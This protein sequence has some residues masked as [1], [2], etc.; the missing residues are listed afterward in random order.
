MERIFLFLYIKVLEGLSVIKFIFFEELEY[1]RI[2]FGIFIVL[3]IF[4][5]DLG[6]SLYELL[7]VN[8]FLF[9]EN[10]LLIFC[11]LLFSVI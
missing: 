2:L 7:E 8:I 11:M 10:Y 6:F 1:L 3:V 9:L 4:V 5:F